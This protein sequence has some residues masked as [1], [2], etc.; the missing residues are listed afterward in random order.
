LVFFSDIL[1]ELKKSAGTAK[2]TPTAQ[3]QVK[4]ARRKRKAGGRYKIKGN[5]KINNSRI[6]RRA[7]HMPS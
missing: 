4:G 2:G 5:R 6:A 3:N 7:I 1:P